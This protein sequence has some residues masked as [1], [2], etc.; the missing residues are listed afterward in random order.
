MRFGDK[1]KSNSLYA[2]DSRLGQAVLKFF[3]ARI[4]A[5]NVQEEQ[6]L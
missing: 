2:E 3:K 4:F 6:Q 1:L 5:L